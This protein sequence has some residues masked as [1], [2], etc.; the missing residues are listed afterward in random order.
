[1]SAILACCIILSSYLKG[2]LIS[3]LQL[4]KILATSLATALAFSAGGIEAM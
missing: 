3:I 4:G 1:M 2:G